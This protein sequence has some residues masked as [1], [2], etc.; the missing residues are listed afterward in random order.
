M[1]LY[2]FWRSSCTWRVRIALGYKGIAHEYVP[3]DLVKDGGEQHREEFGAVNPQRQVPVL[4]I[5]VGGAPLRLAQS[6]AII[7][8]LDERYPEPRLLPVDRY[9]RARTRQLVEIVN[10]GIQPFQNTTTQKILR[11]ELHADDRAFARRFIERGLLS[12]QAVA[13]ETAGRYCVG[14]EVSMADAFL[15]PQLYHARRFGVDFAAL[16]TLARIEE[17]CMALP[18]FQA[19]HADRQPDAPKPA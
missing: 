14:D 1:K 3:V 18:A 6:V 16:P 11:E 12:F 9:L 7:E 15:V 17:A 8:F 2:G 10:A 4:E 13:E 19:A 5:E